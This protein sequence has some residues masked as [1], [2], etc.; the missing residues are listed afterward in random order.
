MIT[1]LN[2]RVG[3]AILLAQS[4]EFRGTATVIV[5]PA[6]AANDSVNMKERWDAGLRARLG[7]L[8]TPGAMLFGTARRGVAARGSDDELQRSRD[9]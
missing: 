7:Y 5:P 2:L 4:R 1:D 6:R 8:V 9:L 3:S